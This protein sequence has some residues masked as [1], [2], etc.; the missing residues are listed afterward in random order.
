MYRNDNRTVVTLDAG[1]TFFRFTAIQGNKPVSQTV[2]YPSEAKNLEKCLQNLLKGFEDVFAQLPEKPTAISFA[3]P[4]PADYPNG[5]FPTR[6]TN[7]PAFADGIALGPFL[8]EKFDLPVFINNDA[9]LFTYGEA[10]A[11]ALPDINRKLAETG[12]PKQ[13]KNLIGFILGTGFGF[14]LTTNNNMYI[15]DNCCSEMYCLPHKTEPELIVEEGVSQ[16]AILNHYKKHA[17]DTNAQDYTDSYDIYRIADGTLAGDQVAAKQAFATF[18]EIAGYAIAYAAC[19]LD[20]IIVLGGGVSK[21]SKFYMPA[22]LKELRSTISTRSGITL[23]KVPSYVYNLDDETEF[24]Q[25][26]KGDVR[27]FTI[28]GT[29]KKVYCDSQKRLG[30]TVSHLGTSVAT[31]IGAYSFALHSIDNQ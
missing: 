22:L 8:K 28:P 6:L 20:G 2:E 17:N 10:L 3:F 23:P 26:A 4:G 5:I 25:F 31:S 30:I 12:S 29:A 9:D 11:G 24:Q 19:M 1:G 7:F 16:R 13:Y 14:G 21:G 27:E 18:G 15:G